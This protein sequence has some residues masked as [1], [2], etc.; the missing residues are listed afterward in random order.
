M[1]A[2]DLYCELERARWM[3]CDTDSFALFLP[4][5][6]SF[7]Y[8]RTATS[9]HRLH[10]LHSILRNIFGLFSIRFGRTFSLF[11]Q[12]FSL[13]EIC[14]FFIS[15]FALL[16]LHGVLKKKYSWSA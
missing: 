7:E 8:T 16:I 11:R 2:F 14:L 10:W 5:D 3:A 13:F 6:H 1:L 4:Y 12:N 9:S 15:C